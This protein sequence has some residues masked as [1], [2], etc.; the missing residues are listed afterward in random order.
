M[1]RQGARALNGPI[2]SALNRRGTATSDMKDA[3][4]KALLK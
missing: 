1:N 3:A 2:I 4:R